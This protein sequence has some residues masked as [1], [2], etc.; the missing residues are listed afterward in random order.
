MDMTFYISWAK[1]LDS[2]QVMGSGRENVAAPDRESRVEKL[3]TVAQ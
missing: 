2:F 3:M 1:V